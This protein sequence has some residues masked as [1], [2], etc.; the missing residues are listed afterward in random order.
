M[1]DGALRV[2]VS[3]AT[4]ATGNLVVGL[5]ARTDGARL[6]GALAA[7]G[8]ADL[9]RELAPGVVLTSDPA[10]AIR[11]ADVAVDFSTPAAVEGLLLALDARPIPVAI[12][13]TALSEPLVEAIHTLAGRVP[14]LLAPNMSLGVNVLRQLVR[15]AVCAVGDGWDAE[16]V[17]VHHRRKVDAPSGTALA[18]AQDLASACARADEVGIELG[19]RGAAGPRAQGAIGVH[20]VRGGDV[21]GEHTVMLLGDGER[22]ELVHRA[23]DRRTFAAGALRAARWLAHPD[24]EPG[25]Y[26]MADV[27][28]R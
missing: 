28:A 15:D 4:G 25:L 23:S 26:C 2:A 7:P 18:L 11:D 6:A 27:L 14:V 24:R 16:I 9:G 20:A 1:A 13:T 5:L 8:E 22:I 12:G 3:G 19:R 17:E 10:D 21:V